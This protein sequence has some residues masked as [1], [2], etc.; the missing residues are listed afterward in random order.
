MADG[1]FLFFGVKDT[2]SLDIVQSFT[3]TF[4]MPYL[5]PSTSVWTEKSAAGFEVHMK[6]D[7]TFAIIDM[8]LYFGW[9]KIHYVYDSDEGN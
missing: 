5:S 2:K 7:Y 9:T 8:I 4:H 6:P 1:V 3:R